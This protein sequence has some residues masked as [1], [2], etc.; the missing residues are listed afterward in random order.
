[1]D[2]ADISVPIISWPSCPNMVSSFDGSFNQTTK[3]FWLPA[4]CCVGLPVCV[5]LCVCVWVW[6]CLRADMESFGVRI[7]CSEEDIFFQI[8]MNLFPFC[9]RVLKA[10][11][12]SKLVFANSELQC[13]AFKNMMNTRTHTTDIHAHIHTSLFQPDSTLPFSPFFFFSFSFLQVF[14]SLLLV[15]FVTSFCSSLLIAVIVSVLHHWWSHVL[16]VYH[17]EGEGDRERE[18]ERG[19]LCISLSLILSSAPTDTRILSD[20]HSSSP[21]QPEGGTHGHR[22]QKTTK[23]DCTSSTPQVQ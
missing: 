10:W 6:G 23:P 17:Q 12:I 2:D 19:R 8:W 5:C 9:Q 15:P 14:S 13:P 21:L 20:V 11:V 1:M 3:L 18:V 4:G 22:D 16:S 7:G